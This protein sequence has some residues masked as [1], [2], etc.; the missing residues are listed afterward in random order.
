MRK[1]VSLLTLLCLNLGYQIYAQTTVVRG[2]ID[3]PNL[4][5]IRISIFDDYFSLKNNILAKSKI[6]QLTFKLEFTIDKPY[7]ARL[8]GG[9]YDKQLLIEPGTTYDVVIA[10]DSTQRLKVTQTGGTPGL[11]K[12]YVDLLFDFDEFIRKND[13]AILFGKYT[14]EVLKFTAKM[15]DSLQAEMRNPL[16][17]DIVN[18]RSAELE[19]IARAKS[20]SRVYVEYLHKAPIA[21]F[22][23]EY[24]YFFKEFYSNYFYEIYI[25]NS[26]EELRK[27]IR[28]N[29]SFSKIATYFD[30]IPYYSG[31]EELRDLALLNG[32]TE[33]LY[34]KQN[35]KPEH[36]WPIIED[37]SKNNKFPQIKTAATNY[38]AKYA[39]LKPGA[40]YSDLEIIDEKNNGKNLSSFLGKPV[41]LCFFDPLTE[42]SALE[43]SALS[44]LY[45]KYK[46]KVHFIPVA[47]KASAYELQEFKLG[48][49]IKVPL[50]R[51]ENVEDLIP[52]KVRNTIAFFLIDAQGKFINGNGPMPL[53]ADAELEAAIK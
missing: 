22:G 8:Y 5:E 26:S 46:D 18:Y 24:M 29:N 13:K 2:R 39:P 6:N 15:K 47:V 45:D 7:I 51:T 43:I 38:I 17:Y 9:N 12:L 37:I 49:A 40:M 30:T 27:T 1:L 21:V 36:I 41:Y 44:Y 11:N 32:L 16:I 50:Y 10:N 33:A 3:D 4:K 35:F 19:L 28:E 53:F 20:R 23:N 25:K 34:D 42:T 52:Y 48:N 14:N 31:N